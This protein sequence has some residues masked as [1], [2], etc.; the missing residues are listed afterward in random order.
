MAPELIVF[1]LDLTLWSCGGIWVDCTTPPYHCDQHGKV[2]DAT[3]REMRFYA[4]VV[5][6][7]EEIESLGCSTALASRTD[8]PD[9]AREVLQLLGY[10][11][12]FDY[13]Q[14][15]P[16]SKVTHFTK[17]Q[18]QTNLAFDT[19]LFFDDEHRNIVEVGELGVKCVEI[20]N[21]LD[22]AS[23]DRGLKMFE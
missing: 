15:Y 12:H 10:G 13:Q 20:S 2:W 4:D 17:L 1:D 11:N 9:W 18:E 14:I 3:G 16:G 5:E 22:W 7:L 23:F 8:R 6:I 21:G 19:M